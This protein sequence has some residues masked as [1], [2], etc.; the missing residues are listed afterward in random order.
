MGEEQRVQTERR[1][2]RSRAGNA[3]GFVTCMSVGPGVHCIVG[4][5][6]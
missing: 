4:R 2:M 1:L 3:T 5:S 6:G